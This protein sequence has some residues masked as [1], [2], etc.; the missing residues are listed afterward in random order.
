M[1][2]SKNKVIKKKL[3]E[4]LTIHEYCQDKK[5][6]P[7][8]GAVAVFKEGIFGPKINKSFHELYQS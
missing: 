7:I 4:G 5:D 8:D 6:L 1:K 3:S 2:F